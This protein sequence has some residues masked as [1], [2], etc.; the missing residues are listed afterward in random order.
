MG[1]GVVCVVPNNIISLSLSLSLYLYIYIYIYIC[2]LVCIMYGYMHNQALETGQRCQ[3]SRN[4]HVMC[5][6]YFYIYIYIYICIYIYI[7]IYTYYIYIYIEREREY[8]YCTPL[9]SSSGYYIKAVVVEVAAAESSQHQLPTSQHR[10]TESV[11]GSPW[12]RP[13]RLLRI[14]ISEGLTQANS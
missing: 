3:R 6:L 10:L 11:Q 9:L 8:M 13:V 14:A 1:V 5:I 2:I 4:I 7:Y 12:L